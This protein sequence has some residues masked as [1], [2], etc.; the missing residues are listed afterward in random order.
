MAD[1]HDRSY[2]KFAL[3]QSLVHNNTLSNAGG[4]PATAARFEA[5]ARESLAEQAAIERADSIP[6][7]SYRLQYLA[8]DLMGGEQFRLQD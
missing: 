1:G 6:F 4:D 5:M 8:Q 3:H 2:L 7:E